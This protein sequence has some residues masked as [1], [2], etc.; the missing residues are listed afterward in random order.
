[1]LDKLYNSSNIYRSSG[2]SLDGLCDAQT[3]QLSIFND[4]EKSEKLDKLGKQLDKLEAKFG[5]N[6]IQTGFFNAT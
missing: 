4:N 6:I 1:M 2:I 5:K 3:T